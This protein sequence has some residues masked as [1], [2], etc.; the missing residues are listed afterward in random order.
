MA[1]IAPHLKHRAFVADN[2]ELAELLAKE[3]LFPETDKSVC[4]SL[5]SCV[6]L[7]AMTA[8]AAEFVDGVLR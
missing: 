4:A 5:I 8:C 2:V 7:T 1:G 6:S 3:R